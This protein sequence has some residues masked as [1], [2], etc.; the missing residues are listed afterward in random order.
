MLQPGS[1]ETAT[2]EPTAEEP[3][4][5]QQGK[6]P[7]S[8]HLATTREGP[9]GSNGDLAEPKRNISIK[10]FFK[11]PPNTKQ[12]NKALRTCLSGHTEVPSLN[13]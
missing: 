4:A 9:M 8:L 3:V 5:P 2:T 12:T 13:Q 10:V 6:P 1:L 11:T 7:K